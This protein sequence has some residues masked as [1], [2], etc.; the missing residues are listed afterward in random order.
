[1]TRQGNQGTAKDQ[2]GSIHGREVA[3]TETGSATAA[4]V[5]T[6][7]E[8]L[9][10]GAG[11]AATAVVAGCA[12]IGKQAPA[13]TATPFKLTRA[14]TVYVDATVPAA[15][16]RAAVA[17]IGGQAGIASAQAVT[18]P[19]PAPDLILTYGE[20]PKG[21]SAAEI[22][23]SA[24]T[25]ITHLRVPIDGVSGE[26]ARGLLG[27]S[28]ADWRAVGAPRSQPVSLLALDGLPLPK[29]VSLPANAHH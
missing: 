10:A 5:L 3:T 12:P 2:A 24:V 9:Y 22:G 11:V 16:G 18:S 25:A 28:I 13:P 17:L 21:Y 27:G 19:T 1:M 14:A 29:G 4:Q 8:L 6:R 26:Q 7:R 15:V 20:P 23:G